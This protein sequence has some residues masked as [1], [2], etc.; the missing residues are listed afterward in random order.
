MLEAFWQGD[1]TIYNPP[2]AANLKHTGIR[3]QALAKGLQGGIL[4]FNHL[5]RCGDTLS[6]SAGY[7][8]NFDP[9]ADLIYKGHVFQ[10]IWDNEN[11][12]D[13]RITLRCLTGWIEF[14][15]AFVSFSLAA[16]ATD[17]DA[18]RQIVAAAHIPVDAIDYDALSAAKHPAG[19][20]YHGRP[21]MM[22]REIAKQ[23]IMSMWF[24]PLG[25]SMRAM[26]GLSDPNGIPQV[27]YAPPE[28][29]GGGPGTTKGIVKRTLIGSPVQTQRGI[30]F[31]VLL[32][33]EV[34]IGDVV[35]LQGVTVTQF[36][37]TP[38]QQYPA[39]VSPSGNYVV[40]RIGYVGDSRGH[41]DDWCTEINAVTYDF[42]DVYANSRD[43][44][45]Q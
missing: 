1:L 13:L 4:Q 23:H 22:L 2:E 44:T 28:F 8:H 41:G 26:R 10:P 14:S 6:I 45:H 40:S 5:I 36:A 9:Q 30:I 29:K 3:P 15:T 43:Y 20:A 33:S 32:D 31:R 24:S 12:L 7:K 35:Q 18:V 37:L 34:K 21:L 27:I 25:L 11:L 39:M 19:R 42:F 17:A 16:G 38:L